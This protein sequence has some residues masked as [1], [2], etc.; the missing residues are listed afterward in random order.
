MRVLL[1]GAYGLIGSAILA[2]LH[3]DGHGLVAAGRRIDEARR[4]FPYARW[5]EAD[6]AAR[7]ASLRWATS[8]H[9]SPQR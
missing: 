9:C 4:R 5:I 1:T 8:R 7:P 3:R 6:F 2:R